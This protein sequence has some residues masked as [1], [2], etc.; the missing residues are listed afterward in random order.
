MAASENSDI[1]AKAEGFRE[2]DHE[3]LVKPSHG[4]EFRNQQ[5]AESSDITAASRPS[6]SSAR[7]CEINIRCLL[8]MG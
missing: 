7:F 5:G 6:L 4:T 3:I 8:A 2:S 1:S